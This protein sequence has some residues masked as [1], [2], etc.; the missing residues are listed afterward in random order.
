VLKLYETERDFQKMLI[1]KMR[2]HN[3]NPADTKK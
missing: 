1:D 3:P 2:K